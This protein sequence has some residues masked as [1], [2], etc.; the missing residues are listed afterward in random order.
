MGGFFRG[1]AVRARSNNAGEHRRACDTHYRRIEPDSS[2][3]G[4]DESH[5]AARDRD[6]SAKMNLRQLSILAA[7]SSISA[8]S[9]SISF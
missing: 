9:R 3:Q 5:T 2:N 7:S 1:A 8:S 4:R 6:P